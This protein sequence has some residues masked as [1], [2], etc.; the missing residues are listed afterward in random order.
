M[1]KPKTK[2]EIEIMMEGG[3]KLSRI[4]KTIRDAI[5]EG[6]T[7]KELDELAEKL[8]LEAG[9]QPSFKMVKDYHWST[10]INVN[11]GVVHGIPNQRPFEEG[12]LASVDL[13]FFYKGFHTD[14]SFTIPVGA[15]SLE[16]R[17]FLDTGENALRLAIGQVWPGNK[18]SDISKAI[19]K[20][21]ENRG[22][23]PVR[24]LTGHG[25]GRDLHEK[26][27]IPCYWAPGSQD[28]IIPEGAAFALEVIYAMGSPDLVLS[29]DGWTIETKDGKISALFEETVVATKDGPLVLTA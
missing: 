9:G 7:P 19:Q 2:E 26:P 11:E 8:I 28:E 14:T 10:C 1:I 4:K 6:K 24:A 22:Y 20:T 17:K 15:M 18:I 25:I 29:E 23:S 21:L 16:V 5:Q 3:K 27:F 13:G 12:D